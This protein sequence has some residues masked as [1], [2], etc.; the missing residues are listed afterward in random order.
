MFPRGN[1]H[2]KAKKMSKIMATQYKLSIITF[3]YQ[4]IPIS[5]TKLQGVHFKES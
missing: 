1:W 3:Y 5:L 2:L 4:L